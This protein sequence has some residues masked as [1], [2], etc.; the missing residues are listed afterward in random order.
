MGHI[1]HGK[2]SLLD[3]IR[4]SNITAHEAG[5]ITQ[6]VSA[7]EVEHTGQDGIQHAITFLDTPGHEA[8]Q[9][10]RMR[11]VKIAD[12]AILVV[13]AEDGV[14][15]QT[16]HALSCIKE[17]GIPYIVAINKIDKP[18]ADI[19]RTKQSLAEHEIFIEGYGGDIP[20]VPI[21][22]KTGD[23]VSD[24]LDMMLLVAEMQELR[25]LHD[26]PA[27]GIVL[28]SN[29]D[30]KKGITATLIIRNGTLSQGMYVV[31]GESMAPVRI[32]E[33]FLG[34]AI[35]TATFSSPVRIIGWDTLPTVGA[36]FITFA[37]R[38]EAEAYV[39]EV[40]ERALEAAR[41]KALQKQHTQGTSQERVVVPLIIKADAGGSLEAL[42][43]KIEQL[44]NEQVVFS[45]IQSGIGAVSE[46]DVK[47]ATGNES[48][49]VIGFHTTADPRA[50]SLALRSGITIHS[51]NIIYKLLEW[52]ETV[53]QERKPHVSVEESLG[54]ARILKLFSEAK[55]KQVIGAKVEKGIIAVGTQVKILRRDTEIGTGKVRGMQVFKEK[56]NEV[57]EGA[58]FGA[59]IETKIELAVGDR[60]ESVR[61]VEKQ[62]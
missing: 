25:A 13:S 36:P 40:R 30:S 39:Q 48:A 20:S 9:A 43:Q 14:K 23:G 60:L 7:Y 46:S 55:G 17:A 53:L 4:K 54:V 15:P 51:F 19:D 59:M 41:K 5:G 28:E 44:H 34:K 21:S 56:A 62:I 8:F 16:L 18:S 24:L 22:A 3:Y 32:M 61:I 6:H 45:V 38:K 2:S 47:L 58:E 50:E 57:E 31:A 52:L 37:G 35:K 29:L 49:L 27:E 11:G 12:I 26:I 10:L 1:D 33:N 42:L